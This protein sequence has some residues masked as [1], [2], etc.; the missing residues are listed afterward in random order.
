M[1][2]FFK[3]LVVDP[4]SSSCFFFLTSSI[5]ANQK[6]WLASNE[7]DLR[8]LLGRQNCLLT[9]S[10]AFHFSS[11]NLNSLQGNG[12]CRGKG[13]SLCTCFCAQEKHTNLLK[14]IV[15]LKLHLCCFYS[16]HSSSFC[17]LSIPLKCPTKMTT[18]TSLSTFFFYIYIYFKF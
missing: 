17:A 4:W 16:L 2:P 8:S 6:L 3:V 11:S 10:F 14:N 13:G 1:F 7:I 5:H 15:Y 9:L 18:K 12:T